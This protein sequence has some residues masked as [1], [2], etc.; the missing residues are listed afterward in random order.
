LFLEVD[1]VHRRPFSRSSFDLRSNPVQEGV[2]ALQ[3]LLGEKELVVGVVGRDGGLAT[4]DIECLLVAAFA[5]RC[6]HTDHL[7]RGSRVG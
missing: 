2:D 7:L 1:T 5:C 3:V 6:A 4:Q